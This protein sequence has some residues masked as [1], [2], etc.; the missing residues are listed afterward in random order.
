MR[1][2][3]LAGN[4]VAETAFPA[5]FSV[6]DTQYDKASGNIAVIYEDAFRLYSG[7]DASL[8]LEKHG[9]PGSTSVIYTEFG[10][11]VLDAQ[12]QTVLYSLDTGEAV[13]SAEAGSEAERALPVGGGLLSAQDGRV[14]FDGRDIGGGDVIGAGIISEEGKNGNNVYAFALSDDVTGAVFSVETGASPKELFS[15][16]VTGRAEAYF[17]GDYVFVSPLHGDAAAYTLDGKQIRVFTEKGYLAETGLLGNRVTASYAAATSERYTLLLDADTLETVALLPGFL[18]ESDAAAPV[19][20]DGDGRLRAAGMLSLEEL[21][22]T[23]QLRLNGR[24]LTPEETRRFK[25]G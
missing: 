17:T 19:L 8:I 10:V 4:I 1:L 12:G 20:D 25:T 15:F 13:A 16:T 24:G 9:K 5:P 22:E 6:I 23:A 21:I 11:S 7:L 2:C 14:F 3:D 18:G